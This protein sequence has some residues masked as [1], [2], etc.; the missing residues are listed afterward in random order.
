MPLLNQVGLFLSHIWL[1]GLDITQLMEDFSI[2]YV[3]LGL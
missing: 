3:M 2:I 1:W